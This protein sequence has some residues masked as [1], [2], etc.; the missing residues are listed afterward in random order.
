MVH[1][2]RLSHLSPCLAVDAKRVGHQPPL[3][4]G[5]PITATG[6]G[7]SLD[8][9]RSAD[10]IMLTLMGVAAIRGDTLSPSAVRLEPALWSEH[11]QFPTS[12]PRPHRAGAAAPRWWLAGREKSP[13]LPHLRRWTPPHLTPPCVPGR[14]WRD[15]SADLVHHLPLE[16]VEVDPGQGQS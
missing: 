9:R 6:A 7:G 2:V 5:H 12:S 3:A 16:Q 8:A 14:N 4:A 13:S 10:F 15:G 1:L 11:P